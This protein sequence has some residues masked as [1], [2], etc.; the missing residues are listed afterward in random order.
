MRFYFHQRL[1]GQFLEDPDGTD[2]PNLERAIEEALQSA[3][4]LW[5]DAIIQ[6]KDLTGETFEIAD[7]DGKHLAS[8][9]FSEALPPT[10]RA[11]AQQ[12]GP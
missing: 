4:H 10:L 1:N 7:E 11:I 5:A 6:Q 3:R 2:L 9:H 12:P 8:V